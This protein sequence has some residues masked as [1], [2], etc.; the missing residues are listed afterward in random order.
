[1]RCRPCEG[2]VSRAPSSKRYRPA[3]TN[4]HQ[5]LLFQSQRIRRK[6]VKALRS[7]SSLRQKA[8]AL[9]IG[10]TTLSHHPCGELAYSE[11]AKLSTLKGRDPPS[12][13]PCL[14]NQAAL[15]FAIKSS[16]CF[17]ACLNR[18]A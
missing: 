7:E 4:R 5:V 2:T 14:H 16:N 12:R 15:F 18:S 13:S 11:F 9:G 8:L 10:L 6:I 1:M 3:V 17:V